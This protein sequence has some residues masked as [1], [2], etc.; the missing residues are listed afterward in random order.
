MPFQCT[1]PLAVIR[2]GRVT[3]TVGSAGET[4]PRWVVCGKAADAGSSRAA[5]TAFMKAGTPAYPHL[6]H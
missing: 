3:Q 6:K 4:H 1:L 5:D 2:E